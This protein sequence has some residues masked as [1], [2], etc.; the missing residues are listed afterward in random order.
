[1]DDD[2]VIP[3]KK[4][5][6]KN[7]NLPV[8]NFTFSPE[9]EDQIVE[10]INTRLAHLGFS[11]SASFLFEGGFVPEKFF[12]FSAFESRDGWNLNSASGITSHISNLQMTTDGTNGDKKIVGFE[13]VNITLDL[14]KNSEFKTVLGLP[15]VTN[16]T[17]YITIGG[18]D[19]ATQAYY[20]FKITNATIEAVVSNGTTETTASITG[21]P[22]GVHSYRAIFSR[23]NNNIRYFINE[24]EVA[25]I[26]TLP[27]AGLSSDTIGYY[28][29]KAN[30][31][32]SKVM[33]L[34]YFTFFQDL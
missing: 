8:P 34:C 25:K 21:S 10:T 31:V 13:G 26:N 17:V 19:P 20:G 12:V 22:L 5:E 18:D 1:M 33:R 24:I 2:K 14:D 29:I 7:D 30:A 28:S 11:K 3:I 4:E 32:E 15:Q 16:Q 6:I 23:T 9:Q 27:T